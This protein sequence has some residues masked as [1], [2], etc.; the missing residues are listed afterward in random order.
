MP[1]ITDYRPTTLDGVIGN[2]E[3]VDALNRNLQKESP[4]RSMLFIGPSGCGKTTLGR[5]V[6]GQLV[7][8]HGPNYEEI[9]S[10]DF[11]GIDTIRTIREKARLAPIRGGK[12]RVFLLD[13]CHKLS[14]DAQEAMLKL[15]EHPPGHAWF[16]LATTDPQK[17]KPTLKRR[18]ATY[19]VQPLSDKEMKIALKGIARKENTKIP[20]KVL[21]Q[22][23]DDSNGSLGMAL[24]V[25]DSVI[26]MDEEEMLEKARRTAEEYD[27][28]ITLCRAMAKKA[29][30]KELA[31]IL[32]RMEDQDP[33]TVRRIVLE[34]FRKVLLNGNQ[35]GY[36]IID[37][38][39]EPF[40]NSGKAG[41]IAACYEA[42][43]V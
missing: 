3:I 24:N 28:A 33:E 38:F 30:W 29:P 40:Y 14:S 1:L 21:V 35:G 6:A 5:I 26:G 2:K 25:L 10:S 12:A 32:K 13:E 39:K 37:S 36:L 15:L 34:Y 18:C 11:R 19:E 20:P 17:L 9:N 41:L 8:I 42:T 43:Q 31:N 16:I 27:D 7:D 22:I 23:V 4:A